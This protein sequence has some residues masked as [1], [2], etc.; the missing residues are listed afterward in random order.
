MNK[1]HRDSI[2]R[3][4]RWVRTALLVTV[5]CV[6]ARFVGAQTP[7]APQAPPPLHEGSANLSF[8]G[9]SGNSSTDSLGLGGQFIYRPDPWE[10]KVDLRYLRHK[11]DGILSAE[12]L[13]FNGRAQRR[14]RPRLSAYGQYGYLRDR[15]AGT[16]GRHALEAGVA[17]AAI[18]QALQKLTV[19]AGLGYAHEDRL[20]GQSLSTATLGTGGAYA[21]KISKTSDV[22]EDGHFVFSLSNGSDWRFA[23]TAALTAQVTT[24][25][26]LKLSNTLRFVNFP[27]VG[28]GKTDVATAVAL[29]AKF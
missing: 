7:P 29:V 11:A 1:R 20:V 2:T 23:N 16:A 5:L 9:T 15:F 18:D 27:V 22:T 19:D 17:Y 26:S 13:I 4:A 6:A 25:F 8:V 10:A 14:L 3:H 12:S 21:L 28:F 24:I